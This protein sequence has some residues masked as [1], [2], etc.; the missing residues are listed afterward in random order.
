MRELPK[1]FRP[2]DRVE[3]FTL[4]VL[5]ERELRGGLIIDASHD[6]REL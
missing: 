4:E 2:L 6:G 1:C 3:I 5:D